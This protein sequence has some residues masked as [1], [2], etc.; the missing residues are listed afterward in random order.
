MLEAFDQFHIII[1]YNILKIG[2]SN[3]NTYRIL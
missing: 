3:V 1:K 2:K